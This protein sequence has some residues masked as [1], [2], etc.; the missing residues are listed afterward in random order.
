MES[1]SGNCFFSCSV[2]IYFLSYLCSLIKHRYVQYSTQVDKSIGEKIN[3]L[4]ISEWGERMQLDGLGWAG[5]GWTR[6]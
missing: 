3:K 6:V 4:E 1:L 5:L 2:F